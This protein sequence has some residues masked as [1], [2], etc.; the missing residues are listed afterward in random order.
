MTRNC[1]NAINR[2][3]TRKCIKL[4]PVKVVEFDEELLS[5]R[6]TNKLGTSM[7]NFISKYSYSTY[8]KPV[9]PDKKIALT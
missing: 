6:L 1:F 4:V 7:L 9:E 5:V 3:I 2:S 8:Q